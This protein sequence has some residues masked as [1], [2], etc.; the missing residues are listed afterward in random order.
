MDST[1]GRHVLSQGSSGFHPAGG[2]EPDCEEA[3]HIRFYGKVSDPS[4]FT[5][6]LEG[7]PLRADSLEGVWSPGLALH[8]LHFAC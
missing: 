4:Q 2:Q 1:D 3:D 8:I 5:K 7:S 6:D